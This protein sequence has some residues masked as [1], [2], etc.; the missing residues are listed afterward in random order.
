M[1]IGQMSIRF[2]AT[3]HVTTGDPTHRT[4]IVL[5]IKTDSLI[6]R[7]AS[8]VRHVASGE[9]IPMTCAQRLIHDDAPAGIV[10]GGQ[11]LAGLLVFLSDVHALGLQAAQGLTLTTAFYWDL[12]DKTR[13]FAKRFAAKNDGKYPTMV[14]AG[15]YSSVL[16][17][18]Q[19]VRKGGL[20]NGRG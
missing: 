14:Q 18:L 11:R 7:V 5:V 13:S 12:N 6:E 20:A 1:E 4:C 9:N 10:K 2:M 19:A 17:Y 15:V 3:R 16:H 8:E